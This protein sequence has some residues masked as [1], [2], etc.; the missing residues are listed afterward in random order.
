MALVIKRISKKNFSGPEVVRVNACPIEISH[1]ETALIDDF[2]LCVT[3]QPTDGP[4][5]G[6]TDTPSYRDTRT[7]LKMRAPQIKF[8]IL[9]NSRLCSL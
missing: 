8:F 4:T 9:R 1:S 3:N 6:R 7:H 5:D 2:N